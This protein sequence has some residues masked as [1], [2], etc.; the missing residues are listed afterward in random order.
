MFMHVYMFMCVNACV[1]MCR[2]NRLASVLSLLSLSPLFTIESRS[3]STALA[4]LELD[5][6]DQMASNS[7]TTKILHRH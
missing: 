4:S 1:G 7:T 5:K 6:V 2:R 3:R